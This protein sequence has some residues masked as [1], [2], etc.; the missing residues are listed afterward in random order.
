MK[1]IPGLMLLTCLCGAFLATAYPGVAADASANAPA[2]AKPRDLVLLRDVP[3]IEQKPDFCGE[4]CVAMWLA[5]LG[6]PARTQDQVFNASGLDPALG[7]GCHTR[8]LKVALDRIG[9]S[10]GP[11]FTVVTAGDLKAIR[12]AFDL[13]L[14]DLE[15]GVP[16]IVCMRYSPK[17][18]APEHFRLLLGYDPVTDQV[19]YHEPAEAD[20]AYRRLAKDAFLDL[21]PL[22]YG[23][24]KWTLVRLRLEQEVDMFAKSSSPAGFTSADFAQHVMRLRKTL[25]AGFTVVVQKPFVVVGDE[26]ASVVQQRAEGTVKWA[27]DHLRAAYFPKDPPE[28]ITVWLFKDK[29]SYQSHTKEMFHDTPDTPFGYYSAEHRAL[30]MNIATGGGTLVHEMVHPL[31]RANFAKCPDW[32]NEGLASLY[33]QCGPRDD[34]IIGFT[35]WRLA[36][37]QKAIRAGHVPSFEA[38]LATRDGDFYSGDKGTNYAQARYLCYY[39]QEQG[40]LRKYFRAFQA[41][42]AADPTGVDTLRVTIGRTDLKAFQKEWEAW[43]LKLRFP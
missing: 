14:A 12:G 31:M 6:Q 20:G 33:E 35:N 38:L 24:D 11:V 42:V 21:W 4:A 37:L 10:P 16:S 5:K 2:A 7:R 32:L 43:V 19:I 28:I 13:V 3:H 15:A 26:E 9:F 30:I 27:A 29:D 39:L 1:Q 25:P 36:G 8:E 18:N 41:A 23:Q 22:K 40:L 34:D 17:P